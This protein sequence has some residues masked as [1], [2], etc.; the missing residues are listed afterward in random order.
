M[1]S[2]KPVETVV[3]S[4]GRGAFRKHRRYIGNFRSAP[5]LGES[6]DIF[7][8][9]LATERQHATRREVARGTIRARAKETQ[10]FRARGIFRI[11]REIFQRPRARIPSVEIP[12]FI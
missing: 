1:P 3:S 6:V 10:D 7:L 12:T 2:R 11:G 5:E 8:S 9:G 4:F